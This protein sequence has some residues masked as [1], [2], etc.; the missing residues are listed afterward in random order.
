M[1]S[2]RKTLGSRLSFCFS[3]CWLSERLWRKRANFYDPRLYRREK[4]FDRT[5][6]M[7]SH[8][9]V[10]RIKQKWICHDDGT[11]KGLVWC[12][13][14]NG[15]TFDIP[16]YFVV[17]SQKTERIK[18]HDVKNCVLEMKCLFFGPQVISLSKRVVQYH[19]CDVYSPRLHFAVCDCMNW[20]CF[21]RMESFL[22]DSE[23]SLTLSPCL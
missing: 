17:E 23:A 14:E 2:G 13:H 22:T 11:C 9:E 16:G 7:Y 20:S 3:F 21:V 5:G 10:I 1:I 8:G 4:M 15:S 18:N 12:F 19:D 6:E